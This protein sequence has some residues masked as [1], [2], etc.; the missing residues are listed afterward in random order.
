MS[1]RCKFSSLLSGNDKS[2]PLGVAAAGTTLHSNTL[3][4]FDRTSGQAYLVDTGA[5]VS[6]YPAPTQDRSTQPLSTTLPAANGTSI[7]T[8]GKR[9]ILLSLGPKR[10]YNFPLPKPSSCIWKKWV[11]SGA[12][13]PLGL[14]HYILFL[15]LIV[16]GDHVVITDVSIHQLT[17]T[18]IHFHIFRILTTI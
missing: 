12:R 2:Q 13:N 18:V 9:N 17:M 15:N 8:W 5:E 14:H 4:V 6:V 3:S 1:A 10:N 7:R 16:N 11:L